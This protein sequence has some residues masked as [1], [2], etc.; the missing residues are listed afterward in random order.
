MNSPP[1]HGFRIVKGSA[2]NTLSR[3]FV[4]M[5]LRHPWAQDLISWS[6]DVESPDEYVWATLHHASDMVVPGSFI[7]VPE[8][9]PWL[10]SYTAWQGLSKCASMFVRW[11]CIFSPGDLPRLISQPHF[12]ANKFYIDHHPAALHCLDQYV[13]NLTVSGTVRGLDYYRTLPFLVPYDDFD[14]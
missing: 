1:P 11:I 8:N 6:R 12:F 10:T 5:V 4:E 9:K 2:Y 14:E 3:A 13:Y 7:G